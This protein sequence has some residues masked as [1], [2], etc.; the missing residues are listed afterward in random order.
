M[1]A[2]AQLAQ[3]YPEQNKPHY[4]RIFIVECFPFS[5]WWQ[6]NNPSITTVYCSLI[7]FQS[8]SHVQ[9]KLLLRKCH[10]I[11]LK[12]EFHLICSGWISICA[13]FANTTHRT[14]YTCNAEPIRY[15]HRSSRIVIDFPFCSFPF[16]TI[17][18]TDNDI[19]KLLHPHSSRKFT[20]KCGIV[21][22]DAFKVSSLRKSNLIGHL[23]QKTEKKP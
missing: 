18:W 3:Q 1:S 21:A 5:S 15:L 19:K 11:L 16:S 4:R 17:A 2:G 20:V 6:S 7:Y 8:T 9:T 12:F 23:F 14:A 10:T 22:F 13:T